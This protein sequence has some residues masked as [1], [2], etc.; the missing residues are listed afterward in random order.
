[1]GAGKKTVS[2]RHYFSFG[3]LFDLLDNVCQPGSRSLG[4]GIVAKGKVLQNNNQARD[5]EGLESTGPKKHMVTDF[6]PSKHIGN[7]EQFHER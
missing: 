1:M 7:T 6:E 2:S 4:T 5:G 3:D